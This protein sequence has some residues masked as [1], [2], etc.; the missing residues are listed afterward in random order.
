MAN[1]SHRQNINGNGSDGWN[2]GYGAAVSQPDKG[3]GNGVAGYS[4][5]CTKFGWIYGAQ[6]Y[7]YTNTQGGNSRHNNTQPFSIV[8]Q[9]RRLS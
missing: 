2:N 5:D 7:I 4:F 1:H 6:T 9:Y 3:Q 8:H